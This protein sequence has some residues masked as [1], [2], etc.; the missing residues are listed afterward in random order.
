LRKRLGDDYYVEEVP[1][2][3]YFARGQALHAAFW[4]DR[5]GRPITHGCVNLSM[6]DAEWLFDWAPPPLPREWHSITPP[7]EMASLWVLVANG[8]SAPPAIAE[9]VDLVDR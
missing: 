4:H 7:P 9:V 5:F 6:A 1:Y 3:L 8:Y 2:T